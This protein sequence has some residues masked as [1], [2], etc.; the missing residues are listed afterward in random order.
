MR[1]RN[2][3]HWAKEGCIAT[4]GVAGKTRVYAHTDFNSAIIHT[5]GGLFTK[6][7]ASALVVVSIRF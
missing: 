5:P 1:D 6:D 2:D 7:K 3:A 4:L